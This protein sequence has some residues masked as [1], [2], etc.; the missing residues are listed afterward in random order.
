MNSFG[1]SPLELM[2][3][4][5]MLQGLV[6]LDEFAYSASFQTGTATALAANGTTDV[7]IA[8]NSDSDFICLEM[9]L[10]SWSGAGTIIAAPDYLLT[11]IRSGSGREIFNQPQPVLNI[12]GNYSSSNSFPGRM[13]VSSLYQSNQTITVRLQNRTGTASNRADFTMRGFKVFYQTNAQGMT[14]DRQS[15]FH[16]L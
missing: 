12:A 3:C 5:A 15:I 1:T 2:A 7:Q 6:Y 9:N 4:D 8:I 10:I 16:A 14:G 13:P 11:I